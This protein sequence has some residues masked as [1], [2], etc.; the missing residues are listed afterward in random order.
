MKIEVNHPPKPLRFKFGLNV[1]QVIAQ[2]RSA[3][4]WWTAT[5]Q[6]RQTHWKSH[7]TNMTWSHVTGNPRWWLEVTSQIHMRAKSPCLITQSFRWTSSRAIIWLPNVS[8]STCYWCQGIIKDANIFFWFQFSQYILVL[9][10]TSDM[11]ALYPQDNN[12]LRWNKHKSPPSELRFEASKRCSW[13]K[14]IGLISPE[15]PQ[16]HTNIHLIHYYIDP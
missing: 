6:N 4:G 14:D 5:Q 7:D 16:V 10:Y 9:Q 3:Q 1:W 11:L 2:T 13:Q 8:E 12:I 15:K